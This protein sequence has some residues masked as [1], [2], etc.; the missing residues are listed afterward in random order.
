MARAG[1]PWQADNGEVFSPPTRAL[2]GERCPTAARGCGVALAGG[3]CPRP[4]PRLRSP[5]ATEQRI[6]LCGHL[7]EIFLLPQVQQRGCED[8]DS[9]STG[10]GQLRWLAGQIQVLTAMHMA[11]LA[12]QNCR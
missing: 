3:N 2:L 10:K 9:P 7:L 6:S 5:A 4:S 11:G 8:G 12:L 1:S